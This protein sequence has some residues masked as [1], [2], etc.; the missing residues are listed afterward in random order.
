M[1]LRTGCVIVP[2]RGMGRTVRIVADVDDRAGLVWVKSPV[3][4]EISWMRRADVERYWKRD[5]EREGRFREEGLVLPPH[6]NVATRAP[7]GVR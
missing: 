4:G 5:L 2:K 3:N 1:E 7:R 6:G